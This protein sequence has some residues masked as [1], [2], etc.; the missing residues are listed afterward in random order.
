MQLP[1]RIDVRV[2]GTQRFTLSMIPERPGIGLFGS[3]EFAPLG[4]ESK[5]FLAHNGLTVEIT[6]ED[7][8]EA[9]KGNGV[10]KAVYLSRRSSPEGDKEYLEPRT[11]T[12]TSTRLDAATDPLAEARRRGDLLATLRLGNRPPDL[13]EGSFGPPRKTDDS[14]ALPAGTVGV[15]SRVDEKGFV[16]ISLAEVGNV[17][18]GE[19]LTVARQNDQIYGVLEHVPEQVGR[20]QV[21]ESRQEDAVAR[22][23]QTR[24][25]RSGTRYAQD[26]IQP[27]DEVIRPK[28]TPPAPQPDEQK[29]EARKTS[30]DNLKALMLAMHNYHDTYRHFPPAVVHGRD[31]QGGPPH[32]WR[33]ALLPFL[34]EH[35]LYNEYRFDE[36][37]D[38]EHNKQ[39]LA[40]MPSV[41]RSP[42]DA[43]DSTNA[44]YFGLVLAG[45][46]SHGGASSLEAIGSVGTTALGSAAGGLLPS[47]GALGAPATPAGGDATASGAPA[48]GANTAGEAEGGIAPAGSVPPQQGTVF[49]TLQ[50]V[51]FHEITD[52]TSNTIALVEA[53][54]NIPWTKPHDI[55]YVPDQSLP[56]LGGW[57]AEG[58]HAGFADGSVKFLSSDNDEKAL[59]ALITIGGGENVNP[60]LGP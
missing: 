51:R 1:G 22:I 29:N 52:G 54:R 49:S 3:L 40:K 59:R 53:K 21:V 55:P 15:I 2:G 28:Q 33:V 17:R 58:F 35:K 8:D 41:F 39:L 31:G 25:V 13:E 26:A 24:R 10:L 32:S 27:G 46:S 5:S 60:K 12:M 37:W 14:S 45:A 20:I 7:I 30:A 43:Q 9:V 38:S 4:A 34:N 48:P 50:G 56:V 47:V 6:S 18:N 19:E 36:P 16:E 11:E 44:A 42:L 23:L 57:F